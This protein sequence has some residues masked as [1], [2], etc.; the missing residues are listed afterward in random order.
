MNEQGRHEHLH[1]GDGETGDALTGMDAGQG[2]GYEGERAA[3]EDGE[4]DVGMEITGVSRPAERADPEGGC[5][6]CAP[7]DEHKPGEVSIN[8]GAEK[9]ALTAQLCFD[10]S[11]GRNC[12]LIGSLACVAARR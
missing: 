5:N 11:S 10:G 7:L 9:S 3:V 6:G 4:C 12:I 2:E 1:H 8:A